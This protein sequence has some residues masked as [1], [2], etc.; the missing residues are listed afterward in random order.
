[1]HNYIL[2]AKLQN[3]YYGC[4]FNQVNFCKVNKVTLTVGVSRL[5]VGTG[6][7]LPEPVVRRLRDAVTGSMSS[8][9]VSHW[10]QTAATRG[11]H[12]SLIVRS[13]APCGVFG[14][15]RS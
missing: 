7:P 9:E 2:K 5:T 6:A 15:G 4:H 11:G 3:T 14:T 12:R 1:M 8:C 10:M 13:V